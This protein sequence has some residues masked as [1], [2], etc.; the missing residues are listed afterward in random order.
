MCARL[1]IN[2]TANMTKLINLIGL[3]KHQPLITVFFFY[4]RFLTG[5][6]RVRESFSLK[7]NIILCTGIHRNNSYVVH[8]RSAR[9]IATSSRF[10]LPRDDGSDKVTTGKG[11]KRR[12]TGGGSKGDKT[13]QEVSCPKCGSPTTT[14]GTFVGKSFLC[15]VKLF[16][17]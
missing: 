5:L 13:T 4:A 9:H 15:A 17:S 1:S 8:N 6:Q 12:S 11:D 16:G 10:L 2:F 14:V 3:R 7:S